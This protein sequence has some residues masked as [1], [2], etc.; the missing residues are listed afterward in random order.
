[1]AGPDRRC[2]RCAHVRPGFRHADDALDATSGSPRR[3]R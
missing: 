2:V 3:T 1:V